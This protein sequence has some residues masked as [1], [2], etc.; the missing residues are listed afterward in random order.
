[1]QLAINDC[2]LNELIFSL[3]EAGLLN[4]TVKN[5]ALITTQ[6]LALLV[7]NK[8]KTAF[9]ENQPCSITITPAGDP[10]AFTKNPDTELFGLN[11]LLDLDIKCLPENSTDGEFMQAVTL[12]IDLNTELTFNV[13]Y[14]IL[15]K[16]TL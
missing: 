4:I 10:P 12:E 1:M 2:T 13:T 8:L 6:E 5:E 11:T 7:G 16:G 9:G 3:D 14:S 15:I